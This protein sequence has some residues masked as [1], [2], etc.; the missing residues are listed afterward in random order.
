[1]TGSGAHLVSLTAAIQERVS[2]LCAAGL[3]IV[4]SPAIV[5][6]AYF[7]AILWHSS[8]LLELDHPW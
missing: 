3:F 1:V 4:G 6:H 8:C 7:G 5:T 2:A